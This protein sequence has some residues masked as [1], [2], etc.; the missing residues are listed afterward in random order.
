MTETNKFQKDLVN[1]ISSQ[2]KELFTKS[3]ELYNKYAEGKIVF[4][5]AVHTLEQHLEDIILDLVNLTMEGSNH[6]L[7][8]AIDLLDLELEG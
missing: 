5:S 7:K 8:Q 2:Q 3:M 4:I 1:F 6:N